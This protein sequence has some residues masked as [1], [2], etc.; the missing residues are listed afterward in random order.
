MGH[1]LFSWWFL[2]I[3]FFSGSAYSKVE[4]RVI[5]KEAHTSSEVTLTIEIPIP[6]G[7][8]E[9]SVLAQM[10]DS[11]NDGV[12]DQNFKTALPV[13]HATIIKDLGKNQ[14][15]AKDRN[16]QLRKIQYHLSCPAKPGQYLIEV[17]TRQEPVEKSKQ[18]PLLV[19]SRQVNATENE[20]SALNN[21]SAEVPQVVLAELYR[22][23]RY[24][25][26][27]QL[28]T[29]VIWKINARGEKKQ[30]TID[31]V[32]TDPQWAPSG[33]NSRWLAYSF[34]A[35]QDAAFDIWIMNTENPSDR[36]PITTSAEDDLSPIWS[37]E[38]D[39][40]A[41]V[42]GDT[43]F[44]AP[45][46]RK[47]EPE[48]LVTQVGLKEILSWDA[49]SQNLIYLTIVP[50]A[51]VKQIWAVDSISKKSKVLA[52]NPLW[53]LVKG[54]NANKSRDRLLFEWRG[55]TSKEIDVFALDFPGLMSVNLS[56]GFRQV[57]CVK[58]SL[59]ADGQQVVFV[60]KPIP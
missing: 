38:G 16:P 46:D 33:K 34:A 2:L 24:K 42:R 40:I 8:I 53:H 44:I 35:S 9:I 18:I 6:E 7:E 54:V 21:W 10:I 25:D 45:I 30:L 5:P 55:R 15:Y 48:V 29:S 20:A 51:K 12:I 52:Y 23:L 47:S 36:I 26:T 41:F 19:Y 4:L 50:E 39:R 32:A 17:K 49:K 28:R 22:S 27:D 59:S 31:G 1:W 56:K 13:G 11:D 58:P 57:Q 37:P 14:P 3:V 43:V 60:V